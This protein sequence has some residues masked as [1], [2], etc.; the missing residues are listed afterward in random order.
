MAI[1]IALD[2]MG[3]DH[4]VRVTVPAAIDFLK[5]ESDVSI[6]LVGLV[7][8][9]ER[10]LRRNGITTLERLSV[11]GATE[12]V[13]M[14]DPPAQALR[15]KRDSSMRIRSH[16]RSPHRRTRATPAIQKGDGG[17]GPDGAVGLR[18]LAM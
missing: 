14:D 13:A 3:G 12:V 17:E 8:D 4:G 15:G 18:P 2:C 7:D 10:E 11:Q 5:R 1:T 16:H 6:V 9:I